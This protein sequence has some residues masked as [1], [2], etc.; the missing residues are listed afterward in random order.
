M[1]ELSLTEGDAKNEY[2]AVRG[3]G[4]AG[5]TRREGEGEES[6]DSVLSRRLLLH[7]NDCF[8][9]LSQL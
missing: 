1:R 5:R 4:L 9:G 8:K 7:P 6:G 3:T 2:K